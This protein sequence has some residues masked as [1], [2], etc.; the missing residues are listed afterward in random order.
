MRASFSGMWKPGKAGWHSA[1]K[2]RLWKS[3]VSIV[4]LESQGTQLSLCM[5]IYSVLDLLDK[6]P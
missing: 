6:S 5:V 2:E 3:W 1:E 4:G